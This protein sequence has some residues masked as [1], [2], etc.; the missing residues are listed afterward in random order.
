MVTIWAEIWDHW[1]Y[2]LAGGGAALGAGAT[3]LAA[4]I[5]QRNRALLR[6]DLLSGST[7]TLVLLLRPDGGIAD[8]NEAAA[9]TYG[10]SRQEML[11]L[12]MRDLCT[13]DPTPEILDKYI[14]RE[15][16]S[17][18]YEGRHRRK[19][20]E[21]FAVETTSTAS[22]IHGEKLALLLVQDIT[23][24]KRQEAAR[25]LL[26]DMARRLLQ[27]EPLER[28]LAH[29]CS[30]LASLFGYPLV[31][32]GLREP[33]GAV[34]I[35][36]R[37]GSG[38]ARLDPITPRWA[39]EPTGPT[40]K[41]MAT[42]E[43]QLTWVEPDERILI[44]PQAAHVYG[45][46]TVLS[47]PLAV[48]GRTLGALSLYS[49]DHDAF[50]PIQVQHLRYFADQVA[51]TMQAYE[52]QQHADAHLRYLA[53]HDPLTGL[54]N[55][56]ALQEHLRAVAGRARP[57]RQAAL[58]LMDLDHFKLINDALGHTG[59]DDFLR[60]LARVLQA[61]LPAGELL[62]RFHGDEFAVVLENATPDV[63]RAMADR[64]HH[65]VTEFKFELGCRTLTP[66]G[67]SV[68]IA[69]TDGAIGDTGLLALADAALYT[70]KEQGKNQ[71]AL[72][73]SDQDRSGALAEENRLAAAV[74]AAA[75][76][77]SLVLLF[78]PVVR[79]SSG[80]VDHYEALL[81]LP[82]GV[83]LLSPKAFVRAAERFRLMPAVDRW[84]VGRVLTL[85]EGRPDIRVSVNLSGQSLSDEAL[86]ADLEAL[87]TARRAVAGR[88][89]LEITETVAISD[90][91]RI[92]A[93]MQRV[94]ALGV[95]FAL[96]DFGMGFSSFAY[97]RALPTDSVK[98]DGSFI[99]NLDTDSTNRSLVQAIN[100]T[101][102]ILGKTV[103][104]EWVENE[105]IAETVRD[106]GIEYGQG[107]RFGAP[108]AEI[109]FL[110]V[111]E[112]AAL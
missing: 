73:Q 16:G 5:R 6:Y 91:E 90:L 39:P 66:A 97:L 50:D 51:L 8:A 77:D 65:V 94:K 23:K 46:W 55:R 54:P 35:L 67:A 76:G 43:Q 19:N 112:P 86:L 15:V 7:Q 78:Q 74:R 18:T 68:G 41:A 21:T 33:D 32:V 22:D 9:R 62:A 75:R 57:D 29:L 106:L 102:H 63:A 72:Y 1:Y 56:W 70:A 27:K 36:A 31:W 52:E 12:N 24:R 104:A 40:S 100:Q 111:E 3:M 109:P 87:L 28:I 14:F 88:L 81:R 30:E 48:Q 69:M 99:R 80:A 110:I 95:R 13:S 38:T 64:L 89:T 47:L 49:P 107:Y 103:V 11:R 101:A 10:Y 45:A 98:I 44:E 84:V 92:G 37:A 25:A 53:M 83:E 4:V 42:G 61:S 60:A 26:H 96:D 17:R 108:A 71:V 59:G 82:T 20:G 2:L 105:A 58:L 79:L 34:R 93:W 85:L